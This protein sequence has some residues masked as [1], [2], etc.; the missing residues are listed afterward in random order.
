[1]TPQVFDSAGI[2]HLTN[3]V[4]LKSKMT[5]NGI[6]EHSL[7]IINSVLYII[8]RNFRL[9]DL[10]EVA[11]ERV[12]L[13]LPLLLPVRIIPKLVH[14]H[15]QLNITLIRRMRG[16]RFKHRNNEVFFRITDNIKRNRNITLFK[17]HNTES[18]SMSYLTFRHHASSV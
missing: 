10:K 8:Y 1:M 18:S 15:I 4:S 16:G 3:F 17:L 2:K 9:R 11:V 14:M 6:N 12:S 5:Q 13:Q 7:W